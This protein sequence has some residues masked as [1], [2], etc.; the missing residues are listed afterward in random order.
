MGGHSRIIDRHTG[1][2]I[3]YANKIDLTKVHRSFLVEDLY[4][5][6][7]RLSI[8]LEK[9]S[10]DRI[11][12][13]NS[14]TDLDVI[15]SGSTKFLFSLITDE[16]F[17][18]YKP[19]VGDIDIMVNKDIKKDF[20]TFLQ[21]IEGKHI[22]DNF[23]YLGQ[24]RTNFNHTCLTVFQYTY[25]NKSIKYN[26]NIQI[27]FEYVDF[28]EGRP[29]EFAQLSH[30]SDWLDIKEG[31]KGFAHKMLLTNITRAVST[32]TDYLVLTPSSTLDS[33]KFKLS[34]LNQ[35]PIRYLGFSIDKGLRNKFS[36]C[37]DTNGNPIIYNNKKV[38]KEIDPK[39]SVYYTNLPTIFKNI[40]SKSPTEKE[41]A[42]M[43]TFSGL[44]ELMH[45]FLDKKTVELTF[46][47]LIELSLFGKGQFIEKNKEDD[48]NIKRPVIEK[49]IDT[50]NYLEYPEKEIAQYYGRHIN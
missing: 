39:N 17:I 43:S 1:T 36:Q 46:Q 5:L 11:L 3:G 42:L 34:H 38:V 13:N 6:L 29:T 23:G 19:V 8:S 31:I 50:F 12:Y 18:K 30:N 24:D 21:T 32:T 41:L 33:S 26:T 14:R 25:Y 40:F 37:Y 35:K 2:I 7:L 48:F 22:T 44:L 45:V 4:Q 10:A 20:E 49:I 16:T 9:Q 15:S 47:Y 28:C 27:D